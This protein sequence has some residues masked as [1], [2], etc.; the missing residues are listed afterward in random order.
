MDEFMDEFMHEM[1]EQFPSLL[2]QFEDFNTPSAFRYLER[3]RSHPFPNANAVFNDDIQGTGAVVLSGFVNAARLSSEASGRPLSDHRILFFGAGSA[4][5]GVA[6][7][8]VSFFT[9]QGLSE[10]EA[11]RRIW[12]VDSQGLVYNSRGK[13]A[14]HKRCEWQ[15]CLLTGVVMLTLPGQTSRGMITRAHPS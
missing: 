14:D 3:Y 5:V 13:L 12:L 1:A 9:V 2:V 10:E 4:G 11:R 7:Q 8:L 6:Q 15:F